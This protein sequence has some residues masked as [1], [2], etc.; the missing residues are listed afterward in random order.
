VDESFLEYSYSVG[1]DLTT[2]MPEFGFP[3]LI[4]GDRWCLCASRWKQAY[5][6]GCAPRIHLRA[7]HE[8]TLEIIELDVLKQFARDLS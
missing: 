2:P 5:E 4:P 8:R 1:N 6:A 3:G 7:T